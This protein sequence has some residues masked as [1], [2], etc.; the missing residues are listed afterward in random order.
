MNI[1]QQTAV[2]TGGGSGLGAATA[3]HLAQLGANVVILDL[4]PQAEKVAKECQGKVFILDV[5]N[6]SSVEE[7]FEQIDTPRIVINCAGVAPAKKIVGKNGVIPLA[8]FQQVIQINLIGTFNVLR[9]AAAKMQNAEILDTMER[10]VIINTASIAAYEGQIG[11]CA[12][13]ASKAG[14]I[15]LTLP[16]A[17]ELATSAI[18]VM[19]IAPGLMATPMLLN[20]R[21]EVQQALQADLLFPHR[22][23]EP[24]EYASLVE[25]IIRNPM[26]NGSV[27]RLDGALRLN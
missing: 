14:I 10:G 7:A 18:R 4:D 12:Y 3:K 20:M 6:P 16:A 24:Q 9:L 17:R 2:I 1:K 15:G 22:F 5:T 8:D 13:A 21:P 25:Q 23:G 27:I 19:T 26:L 11:Q